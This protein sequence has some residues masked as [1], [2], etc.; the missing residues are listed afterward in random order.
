MFTLILTFQV[1]ISFFIKT[2]TNYK[3][4]GNFVFYC[5]IIILFLLLSNLTKLNIIDG[6]KSYEVRLYFFFSVC[7]GLL[8]FIL[9][10]G[11]RELL[12]FNF[13][14]AI[15]NLNLHFGCLFNDLADILFT[16]SY[17]IYL[18][19]AI[20]LTGAFAF[21]IIPANIRFGACYIKILRQYYANIEKQQEEKES[22]KNQ[23]ANNVEKTE[24][25]NEIQKNINDSTEQ[26]ILRAFKFEENPSKIL[27]FFN[28]RLILN[29]IILFSYIKPLVNPWFH[30]I[31]DPIYLPVLRYLLTAIY[32]IFL[33]FVYKYEIEV[34][35]NN[36]YDTI[37][38][39]LSDP[40]EEH[41]V[42]V[43]QKSIYYIQSILV[44]SYQI[45]AKFIIPLL[46]LLIFLNRFTDLKSL[47]SRYEIKNVNN[48]RFSL[49]HV[50]DYN[51]K[52]QIFNDYADW[53][54]LITTNFQKIVE[55]RKKSHYNK[56]IF[57][58]EVKQGMGI[59]SRKLGKGTLDFSKEIL[60]RFS[61]FGF[62]TEEV[63]QEI[64]SFVLFQ[65]FLISYSVNIGYILFMRKTYNL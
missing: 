17:E 6:F 2:I 27:R 4:D 43:H 28:L 14:T 11:F 30:F 65:Y 19:I 55:E 64:I 37:R 25:N 39:L 16:F 63:A 53:N 36:N 5:S 18:I 44:V 35:L 3:L 32:V 7:F 10:F 56:Y 49:D 47:N 62:L 8:S 21:A 48:L 57:I 61:K 31:M 60:R 59:Y 38:T 15:S 29:M 50:H 34:F 24:K 46:I 51:E 12:F 20:L 22:K 52:A 45:I 58:S 23:V 1:L 42:K 26:K 9:F 40:S 54:C 13:K 41:L 33:I